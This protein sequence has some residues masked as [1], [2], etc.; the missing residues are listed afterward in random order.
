MTRRANKRL[1]E[2]LL[3]ISDRGFEDADMLHLLR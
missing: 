2:E 3:R 1:R